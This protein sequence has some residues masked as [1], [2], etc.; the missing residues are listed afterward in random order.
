MKI[1]K[2][3]WI[4]PIPTEAV[5]S[6][7]LRVNSWDD[8]SF[9][10]QFNV[11]VFDSEGTRYELGD[12]KVGYRGQVSPSLTRDNMDQEYQSGLP[13]AFFS[14]GQDVDYY[15]K[16][17][18]LKE[19]DK[20]RFLTSLR[21]V[22]ADET[23]LERYK[24]Q[25]VF[26][27]SLTRFVSL[28][29][30][31]SQYRRVLNGGDLLQKYQFRYETA[32]STDQANYCLD[33]NVYPKSK[34]STNVHVLIG[35]N[36]IGKTTL[37]NGMISNLIDRTNC[38]R[39]V[40]ISDEND[41]EVLDPLYFSKLISV[42]FSAFDPF[43]PPKDRENDN[44]N[45]NYSYIGLKANRSGGK[46]SHSTL[47]DLDELSIEFSTSIRNIFGL[48]QAKSR[49]LKAI[50]YL[51]SDVNF[52]DMGLKRLDN[53]IDPDLIEEISRKLFLRMSSGHAIVM[54]I[55]TRLVE[56]I[57][58]KTLIIMDEPESHLHPP[59][60]SAFTRAL[61]SLLMERNGVAIVAT[62]SPVV[63]QEVPKSCVWKLSRTRASGKQ[64]RPE[65]E[66]FGENVGLL[67]REVFGLEVTKS[68]FHDLLESSVE[69]EKDFATILDEYKG[70]IGFEGRAV[71]MAL[72]SKTAATKDD[73]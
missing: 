12:V 57:Q 62:H 37:L 71:L 16:I 15:K 9:E 11:I 2:S 45:I 28:S 13:T 51:E 25:S 27:T 36:G 29:S 26:K 50:T 32:Q 18:N 31:E 38:G 67:T 41:D 72:L 49:W 40:D 47:K 42:S 55:I 6:I 69:E 48:V 35:R 4:D 17:S 56:L 5:D 54:L 43:E 34:P 46:Q 30:I 73:E 53:N 22:V 24:E 63:L 14:L 10:T 21:D 66:T 65:R 44:E 52:L 58:E 61:S 60:L 8:Y 23:Q 1:V 39:F 64:E 33:F 20:D 19:R 59:L 3:T 70:Q 7:Y 68:G